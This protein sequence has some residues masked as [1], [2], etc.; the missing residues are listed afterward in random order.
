MSA[1]GFTIGRPFNPYKR[2]HG[3]YIPEPICKYRGLS[4]GAKLVF[5]RLARFAGKDGKVYPSVAKLGAELGTSAKQM[6]RYVHELEEEAF[7]RPTRTPGKSNQ[8][9]FLWHAGFEGDTGAQRKR[10]PTTPEDGSTTPPVNGSSTTPVNGT[11]VNGSLR[12]SVVLRE[13]S[14]RESSEESQARGASEL[15]GLDDETPKTGN[16]EFDFSARLKSRHGDQWDAEQ[17]MRVCREELEK[18]GV[19]IAAFVAWEPTKTSA[20]GKVRSDAYYRSIAREFARTH[21]T[22]ST[23]DAAMSQLEQVHAAIAE[24]AKAPAARCGNCGGIGLLEAGA[25]CECTMG[26]DLKAVETRTAKKAAEAA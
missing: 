3:I 23:V 6:R 24:A 5:G 2:F 16:P 19:D 13:S 8:Y 25:Y 11:P 17:T 10:R 22:L 7:I 14:S 9:E 20:P 4:P 12:E 1:A 21:G 15:S 18:Y 26:R